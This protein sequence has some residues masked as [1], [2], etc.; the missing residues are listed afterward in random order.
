MHKCRTLSPVFIFFNIVV[1]VDRN[2]TCVVL[3]HDSHLYSSNKVLSE[4]WGRLHQ[5]C[6]I[7]FGA[8]QSENYIVC[9]TKII[10]S[11]VAFFLHVLVNPNYFWLGK[12]LQQD[13]CS[14]SKLCKIHRYIILHRYSVF[15]LWKTLICIVD[16]ISFT[17]GGWS[18]STLANLTVNRNANT[19]TKIHYSRNKLI[20][21]N[22]NTDWFHTV[23]TLACITWNP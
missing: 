12:H 1:V 2:V 5:K 23:S 3:L 22:S 17:T 21:L 19:S 10:Q 14:T 4:G 18:L 7:R 20:L 9:L 11:I 15:F 6:C 8:C 16:Q 13:N